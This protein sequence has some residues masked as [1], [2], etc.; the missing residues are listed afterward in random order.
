[1]REKKFGSGKEIAS[2]RAVAIG[3]LAGAF[4]CAAL[5]AACAAGFSASGRLP[6]Q[7]IYAVTLA[8]IAISSFFSGFVAAK[9]ARERGLLLGGLSAL[10]LAI[11]F[12]LCGLLILKQVLTANAA[13]KLLIMVISGAIGGILS[14]NRKGKRPKS[15]GKPKR[16]RR[17]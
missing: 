16:I 10:L 8:I 9:L 7:M 4:L 1:M 3:T 5:M 12:L 15:T 14:V 2:V 13:T 11:I 6:Q 17:V